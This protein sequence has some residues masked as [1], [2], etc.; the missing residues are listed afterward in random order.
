MSKMSLRLRAV[1]AIVWRAPAPTLILLAIV[2]W[3]LFIGSHHG[4]HGAL[5][6]GVPG[7]QVPLTPSAEHAHAGHN[8]HGSTFSAAVIL[9]AVGMWLAMILAM[10]PP[11]LIREVGT[12]W[13]T[14][15][16]RNR[17]VRILLFLCGYSLVWALAG[18]VAVPLHLANTGNLW[19]I[20]CMAIAVL[21]WQFSSPRLRLLRR[22][23]RTPALRA[24][25]IDAS[26]ESLRY[27]IGSGALC[28]GMCGPAMVLV[29]LTGQFH[30]FTMA[31]AATL[32][33]IE[34]YLP[35][36]RGRRSLLTRRWGS[37]PQYRSLTPLPDKTN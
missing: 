7:G 37:A 5:E 9:P 36:G 25:G 27:G 2:G 30:V 17:T 1:L 20:G 8:G 12:L 31:V 35:I 23:H 18:F 16:R 34:R 33:T 3:W 6:T 32:L 4:A 24:F 19:L 10:S 22:C 13:R 21:V 26:R 28:V 11:M 14:S 15:L 29:L